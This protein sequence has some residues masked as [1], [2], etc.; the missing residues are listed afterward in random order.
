MGDDVTKIGNDERWVE[1]MTG[2]LRMP[3]AGERRPVGTGHASG[4]W[5][6]PM[7]VVMHNAA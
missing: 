5:A 4:G 3:G 1:V 2:V 7:T 6:A